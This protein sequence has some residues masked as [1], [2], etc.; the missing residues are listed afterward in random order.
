MLT[1]EEYLGNYLNSTKLHSYM[2]VFRGFYIPSYIVFLEY[3]A[4]H[5]TGSQPC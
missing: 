3:L 5:C 1:I 2:E 4:V